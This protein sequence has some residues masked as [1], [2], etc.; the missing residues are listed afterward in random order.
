MFLNFSEHDLDLLRRKKTIQVCIPLSVL[1][2][3]D[4]HNKSH[5][6]DRSHSARRA[7]DWII[8]EQAHVRIEKRAE[9]EFLSRQTNDDKILGFGCL[10]LSEEKARV[11]REAEHQRQLAHDEA[12]KYGRPL[13][14]PKPVEPIKVYMCTNDNMLSLKASNEGM[15]TCDHHGI[16]RL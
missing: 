6:A 9:C 7:R 1:N 5:S 8:S 13:R 14:K 10:L 3:L 12:I 11:E 2:E 15:L 4:G 16:F